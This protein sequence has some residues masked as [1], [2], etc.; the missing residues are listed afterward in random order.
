[1][2]PRRADLADRLPRP[3]YRRDPVTVARALL[4]QRL[5]CARGET[6]AA[7]VIVEA[8]AY[9]GIPDR[10]AHTHGGRRTERVRSMWSDGGHA[11]V[12]LVYGM[13][14]CMNV[15]AGTDGDPVAVLVRALEP[16]E[17]LEA[18]CARR[19]RARL[20]RQL[21]SGPGKLCAALGIDRRHDGA[22]L[23]S[24]DEVFIERLRQ[25]SL[26]GRRIASGPRIGVGYAG[27]WAAEPLRFWIR[28]NPH[29]S[30]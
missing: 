24:G 20:P 3:F 26:P 21:C 25:R 22:D 6:R 14:H 8:E 30:R 27:E 17:G 13:H 4:G 11:Y 1:M 29:V 2:A 12:Y 23:V 5:V 15:V 16:T 28:D 18:M 9:L 7:G 10:A 19:P